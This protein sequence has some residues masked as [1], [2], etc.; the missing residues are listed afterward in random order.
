MNTVITPISANF[1]IA[2]QR[3]L[4]C[5]RYAQRL[6]DSENELLPWLRAHYDQPCNR[7][8]MTAWLDTM[9]VT[10]EESLSRALRRLR[11]RVMLKLL[12]RDLGGLAN[13]EEVMT[14]MSALAELVVQR[15][16]YFI[17]ET[18]VQ[19]YGQPI[20]ALSGTPQKLLVIGMGKLG[21]ARACGST[22][23][24]WLMS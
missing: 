14:C 10:H 15:A 8:E 24:R 17:M 21:G 2:L 18:L 7:D 6:L 1:D 13:L 19:Q 11:K 9:P 22:C 12:T 20:G 3:A 5:S 23:R 4:R 16:Q